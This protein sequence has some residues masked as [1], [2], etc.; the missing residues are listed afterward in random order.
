[1]T[2][3]IDIEHHYLDYEG[4]RIHFVT[5]GNSSN[6]PLFLLHSFYMSWA[7]FRPYLRSLSNHF[8]LVALDFPGF[9][10]SEELLG[11]NNTESFAK[12]VER[13]RIF[14][15]LPKINLF[16]FS[17]GG[18]VALKYAAALP[19][20]VGKLSEQGAPYYF[21]EHRVLAKDKIL[22]RVMV[23]PAIA[24]AIKW[25]V[26]RKIF[27]PLYRRV[28]R[29]LDIL[30]GLLPPG[31]LEKDVAVLG[32]RAVC[33]WGLDILKLD[34][35][36]ELKRIECPVLVISGGRDPYL[37]VGSIEKMVDFFESA[38]SVEIVTD[39]DH[40]LTLKNPALVAQKILSFCL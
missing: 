20:N 37:T 4:S 38:P 9:G 27:W 2:E 39:G 17:A 30:M 34:L 40:E 12:V 25:V 32:A 28:S 18:I 22:L 21:A 13:V 5:C 26:N 11:K 15:G 31:Q 8:Y 1:M 23:Y 29:N 35:R 36:R 16:G 14:L 24:R 7:I 10:K 19:G 33:E 3:Y 6:P